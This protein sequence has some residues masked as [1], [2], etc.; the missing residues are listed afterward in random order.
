[1]V[2]SP[3]NTI[4]FMAPLF[5]ALLLL[6]SC[7]KDELVRPCGD[8]QSEETTGTMKG[9]GGGLDVPLPPDDGSRDDREIGDDGNDLSDSERTR[10]RRAN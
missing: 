6:A 2:R 1:M 5:V 8:R 3:K 10:R 7:S 4:P 9:L